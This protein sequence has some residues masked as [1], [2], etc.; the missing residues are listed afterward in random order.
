MGSEPFP[1]HCGPRSTQHKRHGR[2]LSDEEGEGHIER[3]ADA[4]P[5]DS[6]KLWLREFNKYL[7]SKTVDLSNLSIVHWWGVSNICVQVD[8]KPD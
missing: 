3:N 5:E 8:E 6:N 7:H 1:A 4:D 2:E